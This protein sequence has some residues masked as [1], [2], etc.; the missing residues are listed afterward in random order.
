MKKIYAS[1][2]ACLCFH[3][4]WAQTDG[5]SAAPT[6]PIMASCAS[7]VAG[8]S[9]G[10]TQTIPGCTGNAD[11]DVWYKFVATGSSHVITVTGS[12]SFDPVVELFS[13]VCA[14]LVSLN[15]MDNTF[16]GQSETINATGLTPGNTYYIRIYNYGTGSG[17]STF[18]TCIT[19]P[20]PAPSNDI[21]GNAINLTVNNSCVN[22]AATSYGGTQSYTG[23][24]G[25]A[26]DDVWF[27]FTANN[28]TQTIQVTPSANMD[29]VVQLYSGSCA[30]L[31][32]FTCTDVGFTGGAETISATGLT[33]GATYYVRVYDYYS[34][35]GYP[36]SICVSGAAITG[37]T[38]PNDDPCSAIQLPAV[39]ANCNYLTFSTVGATW[40]SSALAPN[41][42][43]CAGGS[44][45]AVGGYTTTPQPKDVW[46][47]ITVP[48]SGK[49]YVT[50]EPNMGAGYITDG[51]MALYSGTCGSLTQIACSDDN[52]AYP[53]A[54]N[55]GLPY[56]A[57]TG[58]TPGATV[59]L[60][61]W[62]YGTSTP[63]NFGICVQS[64]TND[65]CANALYICDLN[66]Y[67]ASTS[68]AYT[69]DHPCNMRG[70]GE[71]P[72]PTYTYSVGAN[73]AGPF[74][75][76]GSWGTGSPAQDVSIE[77][78]SWIRFTAAATS[79]SLK[80]TIGNC[81]VGNYPSGGI[82]MQIFSAT[83]CCSFVPVS[84]FKEGSS[85]F[86]I[87]ANS[88][89]V[90]NDYL[91]MVDGYAGDICNYTIQALT[92][93][94]FP[95]ITALPDSICPG[96]TTTLTGPPGATTYEWYPGGQTT[97]TI[98]VNPGST[99]TYTLIAGGVC[100]YKQTLTKTIV[101]KPLPSVAINGGSPI[102]TCG[103]Q[104]T[105]LTGSGATTYTWSTGPTTSTISVSP[106]STTSYTL[107]GK[108]NGCINTATATIT[109]NP[110]PNITASGTNTICYGQSTVLAGNGGTSYTWSPGGAATS[111]TVSPTS[112]TVY[113]VTGINAQGCTKTVATT[114]TVNSLPSVTASSVTICSG[115]TGT[116]TAGGASTYT[117]STGSN[118]GSISASPAG[119]ST[120]TVTGTNANS[121]TNTAVGQISVTPLPTL[122][123]ASGTICLN[124]TYTLTAS[125]ANTYTWS[126]SQNGTS[127]SVSPGS[128]TVYTVT[129][130]AV[131]TCSNVT[132]ATVSVNSL[133]QLST[134]PSVSP[135]NCS[136]ATGSITNVT[137]S[138]NPAFTY[139]WT[140]SS[141]ATV[142]NSATLNNQPAG[143]YN[144][145][146]KDGNGCLNNFGPYSIS[147]PGAPAAPTASAAPTAVCQNGTI[148]L[149]AN[150]NGTYTWSGPNSFT[151]TVQNPTITNATTGMSGLYSVYM[152][153]SGCSGPATSVSVTVYPLPTPNAASSNTV[154]C[155]T[156]TI[157][158]FGS[159]AT[160][161]TW[162]GPGTFSSNQ[163][164][165]NISNGG[166]A[167]AGVYTLTVTDIHGCVGSSTIN[168]GVNA[169]PS[170]QA[171]A[172]PNAICAGATVNLSA[173]G[174]G[175]YS[176]QGPNGFSSSQQSPTI[177]NAGTSY[178][179]TYTV[180]VTSAQGCNTTTVTSVSINT[181]PSFTSGVNAPNICYGSVIQFNA[182]G[183]YTFSW[184]GPASFTAGISN[185]SIPNAGTVN[186]G[187]Y[188][189]TAA[190]GNNCSTTET[191]SVNVYPQMIIDASA[192]AHVVCTGNTINLTGTG[193]G[194]YAWSGPN[195]FSSGQQNPQI[196]NVQ[197]V[198]SGIYTLSVTNTTT[199]CTAS[200]TV[201][202]SISPTPTLVA[203]TGDSTCYGGPLILT[204]DFGSGATINWYSDASL[205]TVLAANSASYSPSI[206]ANGTY[207]YYA[208]GTLNGCVS[209][210]TPITAGYYNIHAIA[211]ADVYTG[212]APLSVNFTG[213]NST[214]VTSTDQFSWV[215][216]DGNGTSQIDPNHVFNS[217]GTYDVVL[218]VTDAESGCVDTAMVVI[219]VEDDLIVIV[220]NV[221]TPNG[222]G[223]NDYFHVTVTGA[224]TAE[225]YIYNRWGQLLFS[226]DVLNASWDGK[227]SNGENCPDATYFYLIKVVDKKDKEHLFP[228]YALITR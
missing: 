129:G 6:L 198:A 212:N 173:G 148:N 31:T 117:W 211:T 53:G 181:V 55:D 170:A 51:V 142:G 122:S 90:G 74:G 82:Q 84:D 139:T 204:A 226:W 154:Y 8:T 10:A 112:N 222:D 220:P 217:G 136:A 32:S 180:T 75:A 194:T 132:T 22:T 4:A 192:A 110:I 5:C 26:D 46:F 77:N 7:A 130:T 48:A 153:Q 37:T 193:G 96:G 102:S 20:P 13:G 56:I 197:P 108:T 1:L 189:V 123:V 120:Y 109:V 202:I 68:A 98:S 66:G 168:I 72:G 41:P 99:I 119:T 175:T 25:T 94:A 43:S 40:T 196:G 209:A 45:A 178:A 125:G 54:S 174:G 116:I 221:F 177:P 144:L 17:S 161:Y 164:N 169:N 213:S 70:N 225:G 131:N 201:K 60:R 215:F 33:P 227:A 140:N 145:Q 91:L 38:Q 207:T 9:A 159:S 83:N 166:T 141:A 89:T 29:A 44:G 187:V 134:T 224:K 27:T 199:S 30:S 21:C 42:A 18:T 76:G 195:G 162:A 58:L 97:Q 16:S 103:T 88:L 114:V 228:G 36:F 12:A 35:G 186:T 24:S 47:K 156:D 107:T 23:C 63:G 137:V 203:T 135:S 214:G 127:I 171:S 218:T 15:C 138:G 165:P 52:V 80:V 101:V 183:T 190:D 167:A 182:S 157:H 61:Y 223:V 118:A 146:V 34:T 14:S 155:A 185:P 205:T 158:L 200:D 128:T 149:S 216:G 50:S 172:N 49:I 69:A 143:T 71:G 176:W 111:I 64:P 67:S 206:S 121:C 73:P 65:L 100:G 113:N 208:Q 219:K 188:T 92:G 106:S 147:N 152:T 150:G 115:N 104:T 62:A 28:Y 59:Y 3:I 105:T 2:L 57:A 11:D 87:T 81:W 151:S 210:A 79:A 19:N 124:S 133:P 179:G 39:T 126:T 160:S 163:Q 184:S 86:T 78:N 191:I 93:V 95:A 85:T